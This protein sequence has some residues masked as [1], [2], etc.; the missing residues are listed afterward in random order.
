MNL[1]SFRDK[2]PLSNI[3]LMN[4]NKVYVKATH[5]LHATPW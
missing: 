3:T 4:H 2:K 5:H 1:H